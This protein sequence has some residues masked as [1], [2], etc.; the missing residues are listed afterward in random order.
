M[1]LDASG[2]CYIPPGRAYQPIRFTF[3][4]VPLCPNDCGPMGYEALPGGGVLLVPEARARCPKC[5]HSF[6]FAPEDLAL[7]VA[8]K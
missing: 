3:N 2:I 5:R 7:P 6:L 8:P 4:G 1:P